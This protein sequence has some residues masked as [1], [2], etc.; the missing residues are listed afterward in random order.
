MPRRR[1]NRTKRI[2]YIR[3]RPI[4]K[5]YAKPM[6][7]LEYVNVLTFPNNIVIRKPNK[8]W[9]LKTLFRNQEIKKKITKR[10]V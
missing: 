5:R 10:V 4:L 9:K 8:L 6:R 1:N 3:L 2:I 7:N